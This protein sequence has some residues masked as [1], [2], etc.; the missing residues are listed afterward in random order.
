MHHTCNLA[1]ELYILPSISS[2]LST[3]REH[4][5]FVTRFDYKP[6]A[7]PSWVV[8]PTQEDEKRMR[9][10]DL[11]EIRSAFSCHHQLKIEHGKVL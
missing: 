6:Y 7:A 1:V 11:P 4:K 8:L 10:R 2:S 3:Q 5:A 9:P